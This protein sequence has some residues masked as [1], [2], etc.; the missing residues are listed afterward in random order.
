MMSAL[1]PGGSSDEHNPAVRDE[2]MTG[3]MIHD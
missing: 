3:G 1:T 2:G